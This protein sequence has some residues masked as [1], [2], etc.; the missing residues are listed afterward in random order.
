M[1]W[2]KTRAPFWKKESGPGGATWVAAEPADD[3]RAARWT[4]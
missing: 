2:L 3:A 4:T 1:D